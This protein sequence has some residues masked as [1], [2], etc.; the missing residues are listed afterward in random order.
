M[1]RV[2]KIRKGTPT[3]AFVVDGETEIWYLQML[4]KNEQKDRGVTINIKPEIPQ[5]KKIEDQFTTVYKQ[6]ESE[7]DK[8]FWIVDLDVVLKETREATSK[9]TPLSIFIDILDKLNNPRD[10]YEKEVYE[11]INVIVNNPCLEYWLLLHFES[12]GKTYKNCGDATTRLQSHLKGY[13]KTERFY[14]NKDKDI[15]CRLKPNLRTA[16]KNA[17]ALGGFDREAPDK[18]MC[19]MDILFLCDEL[20]I[21]LTDSN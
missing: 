18:A 17:K 20:K 21:I 2:G 5:K 11:K 14:K 15:Y 8:V 1:R 4:K 12:K 3:F 13:R 9:E 19:E 7:F 16:I 6:A 10:Q